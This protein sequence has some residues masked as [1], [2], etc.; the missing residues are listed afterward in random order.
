MHIYALSHIQQMRIYRPN[1]CPADVTS[2]YLRPHAHATD[3]EKTPV[4]DVDNHVLLL[5]RH[6][7][8][9]RQ[10]EPAPEN[11]GSNVHSRAFYVSICAASAV[12]LNR[13]EG[14]CPVDRLHMHGLGY[15]VYKIRFGF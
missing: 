9:T 6:L 1:A 15:H 8:V 14:I 12:P 13:H 11:I 7:V 3:L 2:P 5:R 10:A 4:N